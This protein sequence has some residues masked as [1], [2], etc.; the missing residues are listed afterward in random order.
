MSEKYFFL[1]KKVDIGLIQ[2]TIEEYSGIVIKDEKIFYR[3]ECCN[4]YIA[5]KDILY[6]I[7]YNYPGRKL[8]ISK[9]IINKKLCCHCC[10]R[11][12]SCYYISSS[13]NLV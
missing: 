8:I 12:K 10:I 5:S 4:F 2:N 6:N 7:C 1:N 11:I 9:E 13:T 3:C